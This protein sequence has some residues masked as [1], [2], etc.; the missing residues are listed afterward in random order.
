MALFICRHLIPIYIYIIILF[1]SY[2]YLSEK[3]LSRFSQSKL[4]ANPNLI[5]FS[6]SFFSIL[7]KNV[8]YPSL[9]HPHHIWVAIK[10]FWNRNEMVRPFF[11]LFCPFFNVEGNNV[12]EF[13]YKKTHPIM[14]VIKVN[15]FIR[16]HLRYYYCHLGPKINQ[17][18]VRCE[19]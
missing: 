4:L 5:Y 17:Y 10:P 9:T 19:R 1:I 14:F 12:D 7:L 2:Y 13:G 18:L 16:E 8:N 11:V 3:F 15:F 6:F